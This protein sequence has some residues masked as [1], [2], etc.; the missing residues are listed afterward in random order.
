[1]FDWRILSARPGNN[2]IE[3]KKAKMMAKKKD[4]KE[5]WKY[6]ARFG[7]KKDAQQ[8]QCSTPEWEKE[9]EREEKMIIPLERYVHVYVHL[10]IRA[11]EKENSQ[12]LLSPFF[13]SRKNQLTRNMSC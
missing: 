10:L 3:I 6:F 4:E 5:G 1:M 2:L 9:D 12:S 7:K 8:Q 11:I 13:S